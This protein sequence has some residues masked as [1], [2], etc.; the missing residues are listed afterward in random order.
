MVERLVRPKAKRKPD[1]TFIEG[2]AANPAGHNGMPA[3]MTER[4]KFRE[5]FHVALDATPKAI[6]KLIHWMDHGES[7]AQQSYAVSELLDLVKKVMVRQ[8]VDLNI[9]SESKLPEPILSHDDLE[10]AARKYGDMIGATEPRAS[11]SRPQS[12]PD[13]LEVIDVD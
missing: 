13:N 1:G 9:S 11:R 12:R 5:A 3:T 8:G 4:Q 6:R 2:V 7:F 10:T